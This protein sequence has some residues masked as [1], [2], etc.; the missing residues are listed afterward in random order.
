MT[1]TPPAALVTEG[2]SI[3]PRY[4][5]TEQLIN[6]VRGL[7]AASAAVELLCA[8]RAWLGNPVFVSRYA[9]TGVRAN[10]E[11]YAYIDWSEAIAA[12]DAGHIHGSGSENNILRIA[13]SLGDP[14]IPVQLACVLG[15]LDR[16]S[17]GLVTA[18]VVRAN[19]SST[20]PASNP[21]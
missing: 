5:L 10:G 18:A 17:T 6:H 11:P 7:H 21:F 8:H 2:K 9:I 3:P 14:A 12:L 20:G 19:G 16:T 13:A 1:A 4:S 15:N